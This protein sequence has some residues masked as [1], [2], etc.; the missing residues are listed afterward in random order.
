VLAF[1]RKQ[2]GLL[3]RTVIDNFALPQ[4]TR[5]SLTDSVLKPSYQAY[6]MG[7]AFVLERP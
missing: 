5:A 2:F 4:Q 3:R 6:L 1:L 7:R